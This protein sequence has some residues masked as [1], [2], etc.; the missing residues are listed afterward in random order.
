MKYEEAQ[1]MCELYEI[2]RDVYSA[3]TARGLFATGAAIVCGGVIYNT[4][5]H[6]QDYALDGMALVCLGLVWL[7]ERQYRHCVVRLMKARLMR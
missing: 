5:D 1:A 7:A 4:A 6:A 3:A 2:E